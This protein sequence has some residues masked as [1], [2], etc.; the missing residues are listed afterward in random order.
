MSKNADTE[1]H[2][3][4]QAK[5][6][7]ALCHAPY[8]QFPVGAAIL[9]GN[10]EIYKGANIEVVAFPEGWCAETTA[11]GHMVMA[12]Q[13]KIIE[14][15]VIAEKL[16]QCTPCGGCRQRLA[17]FGTAETKIHLCDQNGVVKTIALGDLL[18]LSFATDSLV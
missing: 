2:L 8:S 16:D 14:V 4:E 17:E 5:S 15:A 13:T 6:A 9:A 3:F 10:G 12:G 18:P 7:M 1:Q 11:I